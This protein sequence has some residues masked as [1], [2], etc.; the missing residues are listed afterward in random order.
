MAERRPQADIAKMFTDRWSPR[1]FSSEP[2]KRSQLQSLFEAA[3]WAPSCYNEQPWH[4]YY[5]AADSPKHAEFVETLV[6]LNQSWACNAPVLIY[7]VSRNNFSF[8]NEA[9][10]WSGF[11]AGAA[12]MS[13][14]LQARQIGLYA[15]AMAGFKRNA[16]MEFLGLDKE[17]YKIYAAIAVGYLDEKKLLDT[18]LGEKEEP[19]DRI[20][21]T[22]F[23]HKIV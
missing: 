9:N 22:E 5:T 11:D 7:I 13:L 1:T 18:G 3:R 6:K 19:S 14:A 16:A 20:S 2:V 8:N 12:W 23:V 17:K 10:P 15:H 21:T 4:F